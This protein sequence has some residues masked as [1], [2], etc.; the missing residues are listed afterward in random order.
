MIER[1]KLSWIIIEMKSEED[2]LYTFLF[3][4]PPH[5]VAC[6][7]PTLR[8]VQ[9]RTYPSI[10]GAVIVN[11]LWWLISRFSWILG[12]SRCRSMIISVLSMLICEKW[13]FGPS[14]VPEGKR[15]SGP[16]RSDGRP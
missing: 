14:R 5:S 12:P 10:P 15:Y 11:P 6:L 9:G 8:A 1:E 16:C 3:N 13:S 2:R 7:F 4:I